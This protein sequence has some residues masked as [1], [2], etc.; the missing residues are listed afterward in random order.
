MSAKTNRNW[1]IGIALVAVGL[2]TLQFVTGAFEVSQIWSTVVAMV[3]AVGVTYFYRRSISDKQVRDERL[4]AA[5][6]QAQSYALFYLILLCLAGFF[7]SNALSVFDSFLT[8]VA[9]TLFAV[10]IAGSVLARVL[11]WYYERKTR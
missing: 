10:A 6:R 4:L 5:H 2:I 3:I 9:W 11:A 1:S 7:V 8:P